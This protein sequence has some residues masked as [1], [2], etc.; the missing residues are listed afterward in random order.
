MNRRGR[1]EARPLLKSVCSSDYSATAT[2]LTTLRPP[3][4][5]TPVAG[6]PWVK[7]ILPFARS[8]L[9]L[10]PAAVL[11][12]NCTLIDLA[13]A[14]SGRPYPDMYSYVFDVAGTR[15]TVPEQH[16]TPDLRRLAELLL[17]RTR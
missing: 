9:N 11:R 14:A 5:A 6:G 7:P 1:A 16:L 13:A 4:W 12:R 3:F 10:T 8:R 17:D 2:M 15:A